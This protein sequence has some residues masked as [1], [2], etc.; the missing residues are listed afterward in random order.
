MALKLI[1]DSIDEIPE[2]YRDLYAEEDGKFRLTG[3][4]GIKTQEDVDRVQEALRKE[5]EDHKATRQ[6]YKVWDDYDFDEVMS[7]L[8]RFDELEVAAKGSKE[9]MDQRLEEL[10]EKRAQSRL[11]PTERELKTVRRQAEEL[12]A[13]VETLRQEKTRREINDRVREAA[14]QAKIRSEALD[15]VL[16]LAS[17]V[18]E[19]GEDGQVL[20]REN[21]FGIP[22]G[23]SPDVFIGEMQD[24]RPHWWPNSTG[25]GAQGSG[26]GGGFAN[27]PWAKD[28]WNLTEQGQVIKE[29]G[30]EVA[31]QMARA[32]GTSLSP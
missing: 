26:Q 2:Q 5:R 17:A 27:N 12:Q 15:D 20:T 13:E 4:Q 31:E 16:L 29:R 30:E 18:F 24:K 28:T 9:D 19:L 21:R 6:K 32:A 7:K 10:A 3:V 25:G 23:L 11:A 14:S 8:D 22:P 1:H